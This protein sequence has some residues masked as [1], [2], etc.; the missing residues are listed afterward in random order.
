MKS[1]N[2]FVHISLNLIQ[3]TCICQ[4]SVLSSF[5]VNGT[6]IPPVPHRVY[7]RKLV[8]ENNAYMSF[9]FTHI[10]NLKSYIFACF[11]LFILTFYSPPPFFSPFF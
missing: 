11:A 3:I 8:Y 2:Y 6:E 4:S 5:I 7:R 10:L 1:N 9:K